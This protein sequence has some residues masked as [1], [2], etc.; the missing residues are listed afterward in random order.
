MAPGA[1]SRAAARETVPT[2][3][4]VALVAT[5]ADRV[6]R[7]LAYR[8][9]PS[10]LA[11]LGLLVLCDA[12]RKHDPNRTSFAPFLVDR[13][14]WA[15]L[16]DARRQLRRDR[17]LEQFRGPRT[18]LAAASHCE[19][20]E[21]SLTWESA[22]ST[23]CPHS[24]LEARERR[25]RLRRAISCISA[26][27]RDVLVRHYFGGER[28]EDIAR[29]LKRSKATVTRIHLRG[30]ERLATALDDDPDRASVSRT[31]QR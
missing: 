16:S 4:D 19:D 20:G 26:I 25:H 10:E 9:D 3:R 23:E 11:S 29:D 14:R 1:P 2:A 17:I 15:M 22:S 21:P 12:A 30:L 13:L 24:I 6:A 8:V 7:R 31:G 18:V 27:E 5:V 28:L